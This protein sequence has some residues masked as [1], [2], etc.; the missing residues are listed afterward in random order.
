[1]SRKPEAFGRTVLEALSVARPVVGWDHGGVGELLRAWQP[2][3]AVRA[4]D[5]AALEAT[6]RAMLANPPA[7]VTMPD[8]LQQMQDAT[9]SLYVDPADDGSHGA[10]PGRHPR[11]LALGTGVG[12]GVRRA[13][14]G[15][16]L[17]RGRDGARRAGSHRQAAAGALPPRDPVAQRPGVGPDERA[18]RVVLAAGTGVGVRRGGPGACIPRSRGGPALP[19]VPV[20]GGGRGGRRAW[21][22]H[23]LRR[24]GR[25]RRRLE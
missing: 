2:E 20:A 4:F 1:L 3:G 24:A 22:P 16:R 9:L 18:V 17:C 14:A 5:A 23:H 7:P 15:A 6:T 19:A 13:V 8:S 10:G 12:A 25:D 21:A 11:R